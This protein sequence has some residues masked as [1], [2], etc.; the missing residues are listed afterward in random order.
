MRRQLMRQRLMLLQ[1]ILADDRRRRRLNGRRHVSH[2][3]VLLPLHAS[4]LEPDLNLS[5]GE[6]QLVRDLDT[7]PTGQISVE[8]EL[9][10]QLQRL[11]SRV[12]RPRPFAVD[13]VGTVSW[14]MQKPYIHA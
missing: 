2:P 5:F 12:R 14:K 6:T 3:V 11:M 4:V 10:F 13:A 9:L 7:P 8:V 1:V